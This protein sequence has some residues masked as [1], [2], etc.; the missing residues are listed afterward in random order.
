MNIKKILSKKIHKSMI[1]AGIPSQYNVILRPCKKVELGHYQI[2]GI[3]SAAIY[4]K[5][6][7]NDLAN[8]VVKF[9]DLKNFLSKITISKLGF[10]NLFIK[11]KWLSK[12]INL[13]FISKKLG[14]TQKIISENIIVDYSSPNIAKEMHVG[15]LRSTIIGD[16]MVKILLFAGY[17]VTKVNHIGDW[18]THFGML[19]AFL[20]SEKKENNILISDIDQLYKKARKRYSEDTKFAIKSR[21][22]V[23]KLQKKDPFCL[24]IWEK[25]VNITMNHNYLLY[26]KLNVELSSKDTMGESTY[27][28]MLPDLIID[29][30]KKGIAVENNKTVIIP[31]KGLKNK[32]GKL[33]AVIIQKSDG[34]YL[35]ATI[36]I[37]CIK[38]RY[39][40]FK[41]NRIIYYVDSRQNQ[42]LNQI[43]KIVKKAHYVPSN[44]KLEH[45]MFGMILNK[46]RKPFKTREG[47]NIKL[48]HLIN[49]SITR[50]KKIIIKKNPS[51]RKN[52]LEK[53]SHIIGIGALKYAD[54]SKNRMN[55]YIFSW[56]DML[57]LDG[58]TS[59]YIQYAY[60]RAQSILSKIDINFNNLLNLEMKFINHYEFKLAITF[61]DFEEI[62]L[63]IVKKGTPHLLCN[64]LYKISVLFSIF[65]ENCKILNL[66]DNLLKISRLKIVFLT[67]LFIKKGLFLLGIKTV[68]KM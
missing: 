9:L 54:L 51:I 43:F 6:K 61:L 53:L 34:A 55:N 21:S 39:K 44:I 35:Y 11:K 68:K 31:I 20:D 17:N 33:M 32:Q 62:I 45:H 36:D 63:K 5:K 29:L 15:H 26:K 4:L 50:S 30:K 56:N 52:E 48:D 2:N 40:N 49:E 18:G 25:I 22:Y 64:W 7:P 42:Y 3:I 19:I 12:Q 57:S 67:S 10:I 65:Y 47:K 16:S 41:A 37:A 60:V 27:N 14:L 58:N 28:D 59:L 13:L 24:Q 1:K 8:K 46:H 66:K 38:Y 23:V